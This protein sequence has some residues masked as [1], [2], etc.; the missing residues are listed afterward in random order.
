V[1]NTFNPSTW[2]AEAG[3]FLSS[4]PASSTECVQGQP[5]LH[6]ETVSQKSKTNQNKNL[7]MK[8]TDTSNKITIFFQVSVQLCGGLNRL[9]PLDSCV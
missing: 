1:A 9:G 3:R 8:L 5:G 2:E 7:V 6:S 4:R